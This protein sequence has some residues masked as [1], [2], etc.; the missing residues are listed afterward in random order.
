VVFSAA[1]G[2]DDWTERIG[3]AAAV[4]KLF[5]LRSLPRLLATCATL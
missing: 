4:D 5:E 3:A 1:G 2:L